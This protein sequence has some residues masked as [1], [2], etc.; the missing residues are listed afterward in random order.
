MGNPVARSEGVKYGILS[1][2]SKGILKNIDEK[3]PL[4]RVPEQPLANISR[5]LFSDTIWPFIN[6]EMNTKRGSDQPEHYITYP[7]SAAA[8]SGQR[9]Q[10]H[11]VQ[12]VYLDG[13]SF[14]GLQAAGNYI[15]SQLASIWHN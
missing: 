9:F 5:Y 4:E 7:I 8:Q 15:T 13:G 14:D 12:G 10:A 3:P 1:L 2:D 6:Q 11:R